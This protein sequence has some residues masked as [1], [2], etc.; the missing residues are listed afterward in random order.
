MANPPTQ[1]QQLM[2]S[3]GLAVKQSRDALGAAQHISGQLTRVD[4][5][6]ARLSQNAQDLY[7]AIG[8]LQTQRQNGD[9]SI[10]RV[11]N[12]PGRRVPFD[13]A[14]DIPIGDAVTA[15]QQGT[16]LVSQEGPFVAVS[17]SAIFTSTYGFQVSDPA[18]PGTVASFF[19]R[20]FGR[21]RPVHSAW[22]LNDGI[23]RT[24]VT[25][26]QALPGSGA[27]QIISPSNA[28]SWRSMQGDFRITMTNA[29]SSFPRQNIQI[30]SS[31]W[32]RGQNDPWPLPALDVFERGEVVTYQ[33]LPLHPNNP[34][35]GNV[36]G[37]GAPNAA[38]PFVGS[39]FDA[40]EGILDPSIDAAGTT[41]PVTR[42]AQGILTIMLHGYR[43]VQPA[44]AGPY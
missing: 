34:P 19:G 7:Q 26:A 8:R 40:V 11:E 6:L 21:L 18:S 37:Y 33:V 42:V 39:G 1:Y 2:A 22:D 43:I 3:A 23:P 31:S 35:F 44:G 16:F 30:P 9:P 10:Q 17:R 28:S 36:F 32:V 41:D 38:F 15:V 14:V 29:G 4:T 25:M 20:S 5:E 13:M 24:Q 27:A 12:I